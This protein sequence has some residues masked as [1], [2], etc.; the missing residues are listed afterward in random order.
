MSEKEKA[1]NDALNFG[2]GII[3]DG[4]HIPYKEVFK[5]PREMELEDLNAELVEALER[6]TD[7]LYGQYLKDIEALLRRA[8]TL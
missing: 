6:C 7:F 1:V 2:E 5:S 3:K 4:K 8:K